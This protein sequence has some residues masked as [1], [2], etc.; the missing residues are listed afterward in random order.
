MKYLKMFEDRYICKNFS[1]NVRADLIEEFINIFKKHDDEN[2]ELPELD[3]LLDP[4]DGYPN[5][6]YIQND[7]KSSQIIFWEGW[8]SLCWDG[9]YSKPEYKGKSK[10]YILNDFKENRIIGI[11]KSVGLTV[12]DFDYFFHDSYEEESGYIMKVTFQV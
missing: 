9:A 5:Q 8:S 1:D 6:T 2:L 7:L 3:W 12:V 4:Y 11:S 10:E